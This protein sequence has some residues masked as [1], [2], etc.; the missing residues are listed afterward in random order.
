MYRRILGG[1]LAV[2][3]SSVANSA[4]MEPKGVITPETY[5]CYRAVE[6]IEVDGKLDEASWGNAPWTAYFVDIEGDLKPRPRFKTRVKMLWDD[7]YFYFAAEMEEPDVW[8]TL[9]Q[10][11]AIIFYDN[12]FEVFID[13]NGDTHEY[14]E[15]EMNALNTGWDLFLAR[16]TGMADRLSMPGTSRD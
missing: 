16:P 3:L 15:F 10:R 12:D 7:D 9:T 6:P 8:G 11:D 4:G 13:P 14:Y 5:I 2:L 1:M